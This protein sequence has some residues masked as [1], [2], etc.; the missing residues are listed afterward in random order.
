MGDIPVATI[1]GA[2]AV[3][4]AAAV[5]VFK[6]SLRGELLCPDDHDYDRARKIWNGMV[7]R[8]PAMIVQCAGVADVINAVNFV[9]RKNLLVAVRSGGHNVAGT[10][11]CDGGIMI[12]LSRMK[13]V[14]VDPMNRTARADPGLTWGEF[15]RETQAF[16]LA[17]TG[18]ICSET[19]ITGVTLGGGFG[20]LM[21][22]HGLSC[23]NLVSVDV[24]IADG[25]F[26]T[27]SAIE[28]A[29]LFW[30][31]R[32]GSG[33]YGVVTSLEYRLH[34][35]GAVLAGMVLHPLQKAKEV[36]KFY[37]E[38]TGT[39]PDELSAGRAC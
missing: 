37:R 8:R 17:T 12:D 13:S 3:L 14:R 35:V 30:G 24:I 9:R 16:G 4:E 33:N 2:Q 15:D 28:N 26:L 23:D 27:A 1:T 29:D 19:G 39:A 25:G 34:P 31:V 18:G 10:A 22:K 32:G 21:R 5:K 36:F 20:W 6:A 38:Y 11:V 7:D